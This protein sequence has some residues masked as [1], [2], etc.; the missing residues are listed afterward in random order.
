MNK[1]HSSTSPHSVVLQR[2]TGP[3]VSRQRVRAGIC[4]C[5][6]CVYRARETGAPWDSHSPCG[7]CFCWRSCRPPPAPDLLPA[8]RAG[9]DRETPI[10][11][12]AAAAASEAAWGTATGEQSPVTTRSKSQHSTSEAASGQRGCLRGDLNACCR[13]RGYLIIVKIRIFV[14]RDS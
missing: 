12:S 13:Y 1:E 5:F 11:A 4:L 8:W 6:W 14:D 7:C 3:S 2:H 9:D 10:S